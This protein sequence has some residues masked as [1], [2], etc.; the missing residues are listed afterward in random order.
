MHKEG[1]NKNQ[2]KKISKIKMSQVRKSGAADTVSAALILG[3]YLNLLKIQE[4]KN[5]P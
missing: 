2:N 3:D 5:E 4:S 1:R